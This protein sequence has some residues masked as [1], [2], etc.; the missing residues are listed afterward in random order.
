VSTS[1]FRNE[2]FEMSCRPDLKE[3]NDL[4]GPIC[5]VPSNNVGQSLPDGQFARVVEASPSALV[6]VNPD[7]TIEMVNRQA[8]RIFGYERRLMLGKALEILLPERYRSRHPGLRG[9]FLA[10]A[11]VRSMGEGRELFGLRR[12]GSEF[13][14]E[15]GLNP[16]E[17]NGKTMLLAAVLDITDRKRAEEELKAAKAEAERAVLARAKFLAAVNHDLRQPVQSLVLLIEVLK[18]HVT[19]PSL[20]RAFGIMELALEGLNGLLNSILDVSRLDA[21]VVTPQIAIV[22][23]GRL[24]SRLSQEYSL[25]AA[26]KGLRLKALPR[27]LNAYTDPALLERVVRNLIENA[28]RYTNNGG[29][30]LGVRRQGEH[31]RIDVVDSGIGIAADKQPH[32]FEEFFQVGNPGRDRSQGLGLGLSIVA[33]LTRLLGVELQVK[34]REGRGTCFSLLLPYEHAS[35]QPKGILCPA[36]ETGGRILIIEDNV[37]VRT[38]LQLLAESWRYEVNA[39]ASGED[40]LALCSTQDCQFD[41]IIAD[42]RLASGLT[43]IEAAKDIRARAGWSIPTLVVTSDTDPVR[44]TEVLASGFD[45]MHKPVAALELQKKLTQLMQRGSRLS[46]YFRSRQIPS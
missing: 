41:L 45:I 30:L 3:Q 6:M 31:V 42:Y 33:R 12:D 2:K 15:I 36:D 20:S 39:V 13:P 22:D 23:I 5:A 46:S 7:G 24:I 32:I 27:A 35:C 26:A 37:M 40:A 17:I 29:I 34:S 10:D 16:I 43:G 25:L 44:I 8:E 1:T 4:A 14:V 28:I 19:T 38:G 11:S 18:P 9:E 21:G